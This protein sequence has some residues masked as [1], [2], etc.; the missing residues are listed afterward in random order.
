MITIR[1][2][3][4][5]SGRPKICVPLVSGTVE[6]LQ[7]EC[8]S[9]VDCPLDMLEW[10]VD[11]LLK[12]QKVGTWETELKTAYQ[13][14]RHYF[15]ST[16]L[17]TTIRTQSQGGEYVGDDREYASFLSVLIRLGLADILDMEYGHEWVE[18]NALIK[19]AK[20]KHIPLLMSYHDFLGA[21]GEEEVIDTLKHMKS[22]GADILKIAVM[23]KA[24]KDTAALMSG[25]A[26]VGDQY[27]GTPIITIGMGKMGQLTRIAGNTLG[28]PLTFAAGKEASAPGQLTAKEART[29]LDILYK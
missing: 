29:I 19:E 6:A 5:G 24:A 28:S 8:A 14:I 2:M 15:P 12:N 23:P 16:P 4:L 10:R 11:Y 25:A 13:T 22:Q 27:P 1:N 9:L 7:Q 21:M 17:L 20:A 3:T 18:M 26:K